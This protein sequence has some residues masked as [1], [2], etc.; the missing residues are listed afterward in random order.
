MPPDGEAN[1][2]LRQPK[3]TTGWDVASLLATGAEVSQVD[4]GGR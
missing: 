1:S 2:P 4:H 3:R